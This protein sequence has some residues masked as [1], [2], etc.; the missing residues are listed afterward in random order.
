MTTINFTG[1]GGFTAT[2]AEQP[3]GTW[4]LTASAVNDFR[5]EDSCGSQAIARSE[6]LLRCP[7]AVEVP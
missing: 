6:V 7:T 2:I 4:K 3:D 1:P 5:S